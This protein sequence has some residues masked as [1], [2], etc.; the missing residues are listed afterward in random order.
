MNQ[1]TL[2][3]VNRLLYTSFEFGDSN[4]AEVVVSTIC[5]I[6]KVWYYDVKL[7]DDEISLLKEAYRY[8]N[9]N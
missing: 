4:K 7:S 5:A 3:L 2:N 1:E 9:K 8:I 6:A